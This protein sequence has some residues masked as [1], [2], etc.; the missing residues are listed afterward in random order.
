MNVTREQFIKEWCLV[1]SVHGELWQGSIAARHQLHVGREDLHSDR[2]SVHPE[3]ETV[4]RWW[5]LSSRGRQSWLL[6]QQY[7][8][9]TVCYIIE[10][11]KR[12][13]VWPSEARRRL[14]CRLRSDHT[15]LCHI[16]LKHPSSSVSD[17]VSVSFNYP[18]ES[19]GKDHVSERLHG[20]GHPPSCRAP[21]DSGRCIHR[22]V[23]HRLWSGQQ[24][25]GLCQVQ[26][27]NTFKCNAKHPSFGD[28]HLSCTRFLLL[29]NQTVFSNRFCVEP[30]CTDRNN[31]YNFQQSVWHGLEVWSVCEAVYD[32]GSDDCNGTALFKH[33]SDR[34]VFFNQGFVSNRTLNLHFRRKLFHY[35]WLWD[36][37]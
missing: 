9:V 4:C 19:G 17:S 3:G 18:G 15:F 22:P 21:V 26:V 7:N 20:P 33:L 34:F 37:F 13:F 2:R 24:Q 28:K 36:V 8:T 11:N 1:V 10:T 14:V 30:E 27:S 29:C 31:L 35:Y 23:L 12:S 16:Y 5:L 6:Q 32:Q 25:S